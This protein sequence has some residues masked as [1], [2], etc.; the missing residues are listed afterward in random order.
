[1]LPI[2]FNK[3]IFPF[4]FFGFVLPVVAG[5]LSHECGHW[6]MSRYYGYSKSHIGYAYTVLGSNDVQAR[7]DSIRKQYAVEIQNNV[8]FP[9]KKE[10]E[11]L[12]K[13]ATKEEMIIT[14]AGPFETILA[15]TTGFLFLFLFRKKHANKERLFFW[16]WI[17]VF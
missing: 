17:I 14:A 13:E 3:R 6:L 5:T 16:Q 15:G 11:F 9:L 2:I 8:D 4:L 7:Y 1:M 10:Y 12:K